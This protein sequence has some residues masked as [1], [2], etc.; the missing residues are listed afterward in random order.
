MATE[1]MPGL[2]T[3]CRGD[4]GDLSTGMSLHRHF[5]CQSDAGSKKG[6]IP[7][8]SSVQRAVWHNLVTDVSAGR[9]F[10]VRIRTS[11]RAL[12]ATK[13]AR[14]FPVQTLGRVFSEIP[15][16]IPGGLASNEQIRQRKRGARIEDCPRCR[17]PSPTASAARGVKNLGRAVRKPPL[18]IGYRP[19]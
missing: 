7:Y 12:S 18:G 16:R 8:V 9:T 5:G 15:R 17:L 6:R 19:S 4:R 10:R 2:H 1:D 3:C 14:W 11:L 13:R